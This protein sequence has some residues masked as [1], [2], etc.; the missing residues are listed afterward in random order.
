MTVTPDMTARAARAGE[1]LMARHA[2][3][4]GVLDH[5]AGV[6][7]AAADSGSPVR[8]VRNLL[9]AFLTDEVLAHARAEERTLYRAA[10]RDPDTSLLAQALISEHRVLA[11]MTGRLGEPASP[12]ATAAQA[13]AISALFASHVAR[14]DSLL[15]PA[16]AHSGTDLAALLAREPCLAASARRD[17]PAA[18]G[19]QP[20]AAHRRPG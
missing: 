15:L 4:R 17:A 7:S 9:R 6:L 11:S 8:P 19:P 2:E 18:A 12:A 3:L 16:L 1:A 5:W 20:A 13:A 10:R 14:E